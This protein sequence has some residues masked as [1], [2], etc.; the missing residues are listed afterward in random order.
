MAMAVDGMATAGKAVDD[1]VVLCRPDFQQQ[2]D[3]NDGKKEKEH[4]KD[5]VEQG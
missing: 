1:T 5:N 3:A 2:G 4:E